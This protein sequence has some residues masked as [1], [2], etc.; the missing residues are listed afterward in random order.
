MVVTYVIRSF[1]SVLI[2][3][4]P[5]PQCIVVQATFRDGATQVTFRD[6][7]TQATFRDNIVQ[8]TFKG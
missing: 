2:L 7:A 5:P 3:T 4:L 1:G 8:V 6:N